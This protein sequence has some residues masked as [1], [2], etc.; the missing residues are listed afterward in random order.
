MCTIWGPRTHP[1]VKC[2]SFKGL[3]HR[4]FGIVINPTGSDYFGVGSLQELQSGLCVLQTFL[5]TTTTQEYCPGIKNI[6]R[7]LYVLH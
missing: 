1:E 2:S 7:L 5:A 4:S 6:S 3:S